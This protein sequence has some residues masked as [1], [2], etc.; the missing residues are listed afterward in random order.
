MKRSYST[1]MGMSPKEVAKII[2][3]VRNNVLKTTPLTSILEG[4]T[5]DGTREIAKDIKIPL[6]KNALP[7]MRSISPKGVLYRHCCGDHPIRELDGRK[8]GIG[9]RGKVTGKLQKIFFDV[10][11]GKNRKYESWLTRI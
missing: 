4:I 3:I 7:E 1:Q 8:I 6:E 10:V 9:K 5:R 11:K 2:F